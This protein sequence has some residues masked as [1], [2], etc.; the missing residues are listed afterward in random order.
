MKYEITK[1][2]LQ[3]EWRDIP[4]YE[5]AYQISSF[6]NIR[7][8]DKYVRCKNNAIRMIKGRNLTPHINPEGRYYISLSRESKVRTF[9]IHKLVAMAFLNHTPSGYCKVVDHINNNPLDNRLSNLQIIS[10][11]ENTS[12]DRINKS[13]KYTGVWFCKTSNKWKTE[14]RIS[15]KRHN[16]G[17]FNLETDA[18]KAYQEAL[19]TLSKSE[20]EAKLNELI[21]DG[22]A[23]K[24]G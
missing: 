7:S 4:N 15:G 8:L 6:G 20:A 11:R 16:L 9:K 21:N 18:N 12:K 5:G 3:E 13:S 23:Y 22:Y 1:E 17:T 10:A 19:K 2:Q 24:I 14:I